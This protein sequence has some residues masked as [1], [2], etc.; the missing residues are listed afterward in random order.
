MARRVVGSRRVEVAKTAFAFYV[1]NIADYGAVYGSLST[2]IAFLFF[3]FVAAN[4]FLLGAEAASEWPAVRDERAGRAGGEPL[5]V[6]LARALRR[7]VAR[8]DDRGKLREPR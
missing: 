7:L 5:R 6:R 8:G 4:V 2:V 3:V 1:A